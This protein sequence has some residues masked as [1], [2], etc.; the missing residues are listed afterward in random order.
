MGKKVRPFIGAPVHLWL[1]I[2]LVYLWKIRFSVLALFIST[3]R[4]SLMKIFLFFFF[5]TAVEFNSPS[6]VVYCNAM[7]F[8]PHFLYTRCQIRQRCCFLQYAELILASHTLLHFYMLHW[9]DLMD[10]SF[11]GIQAAFWL[12]SNINQVEY[13]QII[14][15]FHLSYRK[16]TRSTVPVCFGWYVAI[17]I[18]YTQHRLLAGSQ[19]EI[20]NSLSM[21]NQIMPLTSLHDFIW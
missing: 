7:S 1:K 5:F 8:I 18:S 21:W 14:S 15:W 11:F 9:N 3:I 4:S 2:F 10:C 20:S 16:S 19:H 6:A 12:Y 17:D 13:K